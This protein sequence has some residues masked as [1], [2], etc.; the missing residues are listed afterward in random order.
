MFEQRERDPIA[1]LAVNRAF[2]DALDVLRAASIVAHYKP[3]ARTIRTEHER[4]F[5][6]EV[7]RHGGD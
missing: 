3:T 5:L 7:G 1:S 4:D 2:D 6:T